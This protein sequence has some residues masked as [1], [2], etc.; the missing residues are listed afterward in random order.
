MEDVWQESW[1]ICNILSYLDKAVTAS[2][3]IRLLKGMN[4]NK[5]I[6][7]P[8]ESI[9]ILARTE[10][11]R[12]R[13][14]IRYLS[15]Q[16][17][18]QR[19]GPR[20]GSMVITSKGRNFLQSPFPIIL[21]PRQL[22]QNKY[23]REIYSRLRQLRRTFCQVDKCPAYVVF[24]DFTL[25][26]LTFRRPTNLRQ[27]TKI[28]GMGDIRINRYGPSILSIIKEVRQKQ[29]VARSEELTQKI[30][31]PSY[32]EV[33]AMFESGMGIP[34]MAQKRQ[35]QES[36]IYQMLMDL[37]EAREVDL[38]HFIES[39]IPEETLERGKVYFLEEPN[40]R[41]NH[42][43]RDLGIGY[44]TLKLCRLYVSRFSQC[45]E[46]WELDY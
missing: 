41:L 15:H 32:K 5:E 31:R 1:H 45:E 18:L 43:F 34:E 12:I 44:E 6:Q 3:L 36:T 24:S 23:E 38:S 22:S 25:E 29:Q 35:V 11:D 10:S 37:Y 26:E 27:L 21:Y 17:F 9:G 19:V 46:A 8:K 14:L 20:T 4:L 30:H 39:E 28:P 2:L 7:A 13:G 16:G 33:K 42:A 40:P